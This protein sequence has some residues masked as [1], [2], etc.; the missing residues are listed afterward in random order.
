MP[1]GRSGVLFALLLLSGPACF[2]PALPADTAIAC[3]GDGDCPDGLVCAGFLE[4]CGL[5]TARALVI[6]ADAEGGEAGSMEALVA[7]VRDRRPDLA[8]FARARDS[9]Q[10]LRLYDLGVTDAVPETVEAS[11]QLSEAVLVGVGAPVGPVIASI[12]ERRDEFRRELNRGDGF[13]A[14]TRR[15]P[16]VSAS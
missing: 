5:E 9:Q 11:L 2:N 12:H 14:K 8:I 15:K 4:R 1:R 7:S 13:L 10:A 3:G 6:T 16:S